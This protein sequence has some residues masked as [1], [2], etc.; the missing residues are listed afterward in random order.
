MGLLKNYSNIFALICVFL[1]FTNSLQF[2][3]LFKLTKIAKRGIIKYNGGERF[4][5]PKTSKK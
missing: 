1:K 5:L 2:V 4:F 3:L